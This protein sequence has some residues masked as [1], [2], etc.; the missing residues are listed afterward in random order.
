M[1]YEGH[2]AALQQV[3]QRGSEATEERFLQRQE[4]E[5]VK[6]LTLRHLKIELL[7]G[8]DMVVRMMMA[9]WILLCSWF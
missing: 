6:G 4:C 1:F 9:S 2:F 8:L 7:I 5:G 3:S